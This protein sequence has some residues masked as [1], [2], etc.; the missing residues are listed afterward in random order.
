MAKV[1]KM[2]GK[3]DSPY[4]VSLMRVIE[5]QSKNTI[6]KWCNEYARE[7]ILPIYEKDY[8]E[9]FRLKNALNA[10]NE[11]LEGNMKLIEAKKIIKEAQ[12]A[13][14][15]AEGNPAAQAAARAIGATT[16]T[17]N[18]VTSSLGLAFYGTAAIA[19]SSIGV[20]EKVEVYDEIAARECEK[21][22]EALR[23]I[24]II[25]EPN[26]AKINWNC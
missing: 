25:D 14:R 18:T 10:S 26:P 1:R 17:I 2:L 4:I 8:P 16:A 5:T 13:A 6:V 15:E 7:H 3:A 9:D 22:E 21:M 20:N 23:K 12:I 24:A 19:Y 11:W